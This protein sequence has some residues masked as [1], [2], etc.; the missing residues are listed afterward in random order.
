[1]GPGSYNPMTSYN[2]QN[3]KPCPALFKRIGC[4]PDRES[5]EQ[6]YVMVGD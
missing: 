1:M 3:A 5:G 6:H 4:L 2:K